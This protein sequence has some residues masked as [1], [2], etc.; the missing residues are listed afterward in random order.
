MQHQAVC[1]FVWRGVSTSD[2]LVNPTNSRRKDSEEKKSPSLHLDLLLTRYLP[3]V[4][5]QTLAQPQLS[6]DIYNYLHRGVVGDSEGAHVK[7]GAQLEGPRAVGWQGGRMLGKVYPGVQHNAFLLT[8]GI[9][10]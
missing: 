5:D 10:C 7:D 4:S 3:V 2:R 9:L 1:T 6:E 8:T